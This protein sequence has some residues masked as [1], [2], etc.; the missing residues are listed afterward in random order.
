MAKDFVVTPWEVKG[1]IDYDK[2]IQE[3]GVKP[4]DA[5]LRSELV[6]LTGEDHPFLRRNIFFAHTYLDKILE[7]LKKGKKVW[8]YTGR[9][10]SGPVHIGHMVPWIFTQW[11]QKKLGLNLLFQIPDEEKPLFKEKVTFED[12]ERWTMENILD[13][14]AAGFDPEKTKIIIDTKHASLMYKIA[15]QVA[16]KTTASTVKALFGLK[17]SDNIGKYFYSCMQSVPAFLPTE[18][19]GK[20]TLV[21]IPCA[22]DQ[23]VHFRLTRDVA[24]KMGYPKPSTIL[25][26]FLP[27]LEGNSK[28]SSSGETMITMVDTPKEV[29]K[30]VMRYAFSGGRD[31]VEEHRKLGGN[32]D[33][34]V[35]YQY[36]TFFEEDDTRLKQIYTNYKSGKLLTGELKQILVDK[37]NTFL[38]EHQRK[39]KEARH[40]LNKFIV[41]YDSLQLRE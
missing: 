31:S 24:E 2:L 7:A 14:I 34:D 29:K 41:N 26:R 23:D 38:A 39:R 12:A 22:I 16:S 32:P 33:V 18:F 6:K 9:A 27:A 5:K 21:L 25:G 20:E 4:I 35:S 37:L 40:L 1:D 17:D 15:C 19:E 36:L 10:P 11:L 3:F 13:I 8:L 30:K 28:L